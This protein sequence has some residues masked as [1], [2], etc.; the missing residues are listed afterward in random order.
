MARAYLPAS[1]H[2]WLLFLYDPFMRLVGAEAFLRRLVERAGLRT[3]QRVLDVGCGTGTLAVLVK[4]LHPAVDVTGLDP[5]PRALAR[6]RRKAMRAGVEV[7]LDE[8]FADAL[9]YAPASFDHVFSSFMLHHLPSAEKVAALR[10]ARRVLRPAGTLELLDFGGAAKP[11]GPAA[12]G[13][14]RDNFGSRIVTLMTEAG[15]AAACEVD[16]G[17]VLLLDVAFYRAAA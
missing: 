16:H 12:H 2:H 7:R 9:P 4:S 8:G 14:L 1:G 10:E 3:G 11:R 15:L 17:R 5:D 13:H 6:A